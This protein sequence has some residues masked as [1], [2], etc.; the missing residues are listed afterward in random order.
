[1]VLLPILLWFAL[2]PLPLDVPAVFAPGHLLTAGALVAAGLGYLALLRHTRMLGAAVV[3]AMLL[4]LG[5]L[6]V[7]LAVGAPQPDSEAVVR[8]VFIT[9]GVHMVM[10]LGMQ[11]MTFEDMT[12]ELRRTNRR[13]E[14]AQ[15]ELRQ[16]VTTDA[17][18]GCRNRRFF[19]D[20]IGRELHRHQ[21][22]HIPLSLLF[23]DVDK[24]K[25]IN[26]TLGHDAGDRV[27]QGVATFLIRH[28]RDADY[29]FRWGGDEFLIVIS[30]PEEEAKRKGADLQV[31]F[32]ESVDAASLPDGV[33]LSVGIAE[34]PPDTANILDIVKLADERMYANKGSGVKTDRRRRAAASVRQ[35]SSPRR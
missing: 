8:S 32:A 6:N 14:L 12:F 10:A 31:A 5:V 7:W 22:Y 26:D 21:R 1:M 27:L 2:A 29:V 23:V 25:A 17:L 33:G 20:V 30:C 4:T 11:L 15:G 35:W 16:M 34:V 3:G 9:L 18:T 19:D 28:V 24:F 13:L